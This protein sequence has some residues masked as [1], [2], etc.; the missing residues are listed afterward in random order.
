MQRCC[1]FLHFDTA[2]QVD[3]GPDVLF[4]TLSRDLADMD[5]KW[6]VSLGKV[7]KY[8]T[9]ALKSRS[10]RGQFENLILQPAKNVDFAGLIFIVI[11]ALDH[12]GSAKGDRGITS[13]H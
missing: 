6:R 11:N 3:A 13:Y 5:E 8:S 1:A 12:I 2:R 9:R 4:S 7:I 10:I